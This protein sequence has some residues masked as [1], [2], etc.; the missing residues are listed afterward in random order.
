MLGDDELV[1]IARDVCRAIQVTRGTALD[2]RPCNVF[3]DEQGRARLSDI[4]LPP[5]A[6]GRTPGEPPGEVAGFGA[7]LH[8]IVSGRVPVAGL[9]ALDY[10]LWRIVERCLGA[11]PDRFLTLAEIEEELERWLPAGP[12]APP[13]HEAGETEPEY[14]PA[15]WEVEQEA[16]LEPID[17]LE[18]V[19]RAI[20]S[21]PGDLRLWQR[22]LELQRERRA[23]RRTLGIGEEPEAA[24]DPV[25]E[26]RA[27]LAFADPDEALRFFDATL[28]VD[29][30]SAGAWEGRARALEQLG[31]V[32]EAA[33]AWAAFE[34]AGGRRRT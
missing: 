29:P 10:P 22:R 5:L 14:E 26:G 9:E 20:A 1:A 23:L 25:R 27:Y 12:E 15:T 32:N 28:A 30:A 19:E 33:E 17:S 31:R 7:L 3:L 11:P 8:Q 16:A 21:N 4:G 18:D 24:F 13:P 6:P 2:L 34:E